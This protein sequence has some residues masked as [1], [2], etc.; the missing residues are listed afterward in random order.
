MPTKPKFNFSIATLLWLMVC[1][2]MLCGGWFARDPEIKFERAKAQQDRA[3]AQL[4]TAE[5]Q[6]M[7]EE[8]QSIAESLIA[9]RM[10]DQAQASRSRALSAATV[11]VDVTAGNA[12]SVVAD[13]ELTHVRLAGVD[14]PNPDQPFGKRAEQFTREFCMKKCV[15]LIGDESDR[16][17]HRLADVVVDGKS[18]RDALLLAGLAWHDKNNE[19]DIAIR[20]LEDEARTAKVGIW[21]SP[22]NAQMLGVQQ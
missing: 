9:Q 4:A 3:M 2:A 7:A 8:Q 1:V 20:R 10:Q 17:G 19:N 11:V 6:A 18:L 12:V 5:A 13:W 15:T 22:N 16:H 14:C 21:A